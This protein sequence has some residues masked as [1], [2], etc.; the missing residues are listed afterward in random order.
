[1]TTTSTVTT[2]T[3]TELETTT[4]T[5]EYYD[6]SNSSADVSP[7]ISERGNGVKG[8]MSNT[9]VAVVAVTGAAAVGVVA[10]AAT[11]AATSTRYV[12]S[13]HVFQT[14]LH[15]YDNNMQN[16]HLLNLLVKVL[17]IVFVLPNCLCIKGTQTLCGF[18]IVAAKSSATVYIIPVIAD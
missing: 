11:V 10:T 17:S 2:A 12:L 4:D 6:D 15:K 8:G 18:F 9:A 3:D 1:M 13:Q 16:D 5:S 7:I 14:A